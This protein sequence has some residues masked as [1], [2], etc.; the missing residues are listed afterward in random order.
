[1]KISPAVA[2]EGRGAAIDGG[3]AIGIE[4][5]KPPKGGLEGD[6]SNRVGKPRRIYLGVQT[7]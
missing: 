7:Q 5:R 3:R 4:G 2:V 6:N 1:M